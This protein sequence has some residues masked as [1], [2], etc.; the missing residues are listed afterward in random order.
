MILT[1]ISPKPQQS[2]SLNSTLMG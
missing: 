1:F 2:L